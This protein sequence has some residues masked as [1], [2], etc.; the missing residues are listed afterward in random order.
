MLFYTLVG[1][2]LSQFSF[3]GCCSILFMDLTQH[4]CSAAAATDENM[5]MAAPV[6]NPEVGTSE[7]LEYFGRLLDL[8]RSEGWGTP[9]QGLGSRLITDLLELLR[10]WRSRPTSQ[11][12]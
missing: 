10:K 12:H 1:L 2:V 11:F 7:G 4:A 9:R 6:P 3:H 8:S 5:V